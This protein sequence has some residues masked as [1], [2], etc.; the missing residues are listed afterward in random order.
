MIAFF[1]SRK[2]RITETNKRNKDRDR[3]WGNW[4]WGK[5]RCEGEGGFSFYFPIHNRKSQSKSVQ[6]PKPLGVCGLKKFLFER[7]VRKKNKLKGERKG[8]RERQ[9]GLVIGKPEK[10][11][12]N[13]KWEKN[14]TKGKRKKNKRTSTRAKRKNW[15]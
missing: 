4:L 15:K 12:S 3:M 5:E 13:K 11:V 1:S 9:S 6:S 2:E 10:I 14:K 7:F 8:E